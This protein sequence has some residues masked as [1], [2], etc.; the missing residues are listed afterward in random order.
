STNDEL[1]AVNEEVRVRSDELD[2]LN[3]FLAAILNSFQGG[4]VVV[5]NRKRVRVWNPRAEDLWGVRE[6][7][8]RGHEFGSIDIGLPVGRVV[9]AL[10]A[11]LDGHG[12]SRDATDMTLDAVTR[13]GRS[14]KCRVSFTPLE[15]NDRLNG[16]ILVMDIVEQAND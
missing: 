14:V 7:E 12:S 8:V 9:P 11:L 15:T 6:D 10:D 16:V 4:V 13:R 1:H 2:E 3:H 5:D